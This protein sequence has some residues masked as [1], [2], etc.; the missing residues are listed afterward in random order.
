[1]PY[2]VA[3]TSK[4]LTE[5]A[6]RYE[7]R[8]S[9]RKRHGCYRQWLACIGWLPRHPVWSIVVIA[10]DIFVIRAV[11]TWE[12]LQTRTSRAQVKDYVGSYAAQ[13]QLNR[14]WPEVSQ[15]FRAFPC[16]STVHEVL[17][18]QPIRLEEG[19]KDGH[20]EVRAEIPGV[21]PA[22]DVNVNTHDGV[23]T[24][25]AQRRAENESNAHSEFDCGTFLRS[26]LLPPG[27]NEDAMS[28]TYAGGILTVSVGMSPA[29]SE[30][31][32]IPVES[33]T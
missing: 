7:W 5:K 4:K 21:D 17:G 26:V 29:P 22:E 32:P 12:S 24:T 11:A 28:V 2:S 1:M 8:K 10:L 31:R 19:M 23:L 30:E 16:W 14:R 25:R 18:G 15:W 9:D 27:A 33:G 13:P 20:H 6:S 3:V